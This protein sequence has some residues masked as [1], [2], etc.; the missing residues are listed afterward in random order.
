MS[1][2][3]SFL[4]RYK[5]LKGDDIS[6]TSMGFPSGSYYIP[7]D[8]RVAFVKLYYEHLEKGGN[9]YLTEKHK[10]IS[11][12]LIDLD[13]RYKK[14]STGVKR[15]YNTEHLK[16]FICE[17][18]KCINQY[19]ES[20]DEPVI[21]VLEKKHPR[22]EEDKDI[23]K[24][25]VH[26][27][28]PNII[29]T[30]TIQFKVRDMM[31]QS[32]CMSNIFKDC[33]FTNSFDDIFDHN[34]IQKNNWLMY[35]SSKPNGAPY[36]VTHMFKFDKQHNCLKNIEEDRDNLFLINEL[37]IRNK[38]DKTN[39]K[40]DK[41]DEINKIEQ[42]LMEC[43]RKK[44]ALSMVTQENKNKSVNTSKDIVLI[45]SLVAIL[46]SNRCESYDDWVRVGWCCRNI[47]NDLLEDWILFSKKCDKYTDGECEKFWDKMKEGGLGIKTLH[48]W[49]K[50]DD[51]VEYLNIMQSSIKHLMMNG[52][53]TCTDW[54]VGQVIK[55]FYQHTFRCTSIKQDVWYYFMNHKWNKCEN[56]YM[57]RNLISTDVYEEF[58][59]CVKDWEK[60]KIDSGDDKSNW[61]QESKSKRNLVKNFKNTNFKSKI[62][63]TCADLFHEI[64]VAENFHKSLDEF[65]HLLCFT[66]GVYDLD[67][68]EFREG[69]PDDYISL[70]TN[71]EYVEYDENDP[72]YDEINAF[73]AQVQPDKEKRDYILRT[74]ANSLH[75][76]NREEK[77]FFWTGE[78]GNG[79]SK[80]YSLLENCM[81]EYAATISVSYLTTKRAASNAAS[82]EL[83][84][85][86][87]RR[88]VVFQ[89]PDPNEKI[90]VGI[91][92]EISGKDPLAV[93]GLYKDAD[94]FMPQFQVIL[95]CNQLPT[96][97][98]DDGGTWRRVRKITFDSK[99]V[100][101]PNPGN[102][103][104]F[105][106]DQDLDKK[107]PEWKVPFM[108]LLIHYYNKYKNVENKEPLDI[109]NATKEYQNLNDHY[110]EFIE[111]H[112]EPQADCSVDFAAIFDEFKEY[113]TTW[114]KSRNI[115]KK[116]DL[117]KGV[118]TRYGK[119]KKIRNKLVWEGLRLITNTTA[120]AI[121]EDA[122]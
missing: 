55:A 53:N 109:I 119:P 74:L 103:N 98:A 31:L 37:S 9:L 99:F 39:I 76:S 43:E 21:Y 95:I 28:I 40:I 72:V 59:N 85:A 45:K 38:N 118:E 104:E 94:D 47:D 32:E 12:V 105:K 81:G 20:V 62:M 6:H 33:N 1:D 67:N 13:F 90:Q 27:M 108:S 30:P 35:G 82:P 60:Q 15:V 106:I 91:M 77:V 41:L 24:D 4:T 112:I 83:V 116:N 46:S 50:K 68:S 8:A 17:Y 18:M 5:V 7:F 73:L 63:K 87:G 34:V 44:I 65:K 96:L 117:Q 75:G 64:T 23:M 3:Y 25:G 52:L 48:M 29:T 56:A 121:Q 66:N 42:D 61:E 110:V 19:V 86:I 113:C 14:V 92:K 16:D 115:I 54:D 49:A 111:N 69:R 71:I 78:G 11:P 51:P 57:L 26:I 97:P 58:H 107:W 84:K 101:D 70:S 10:N 120:T 93:R 114:S 79:K 88:F 36:K 122:E 80:L 22:Y 89:E 102:P 2:I 100:D